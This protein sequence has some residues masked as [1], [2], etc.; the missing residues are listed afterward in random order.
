LAKFA[1]L[2]PHIR[3]VWHFTD[4]PR[5]LINDGYDLKIRMGWPEESSMATQFWIVPSFA[6]YTN[7][8]SIFPI[9]DDHVDSRLRLAI[10]AIQI[11]VNIA[12]DVSEQ[13]SVSR[14]KVFQSRGRLK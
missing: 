2:F 14:S 5:D 13:I 9:G 11:R 12:C 8:I 3:L 10:A 4:T 6:L 1:S 7:T